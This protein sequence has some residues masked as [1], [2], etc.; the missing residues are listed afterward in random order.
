[1]TRDVKR[2]FV[3]SGLSGSSGQT[4][5]T[6]P[7]DRQTPR[8][9]T[10]DRNDGGQRSCGVRRCIE[11]FRTGR[12][13]LLPLL[14]LVACG[15]DGGGGFDKPED[16]LENP[17]ITDAIEYSGHTVYKGSSPPSI[18][19]RYATFGEVI[20]GTDL[21]IIDLSFESTVCLFNQTAAGRI[22][23][24]EFAGE[25]TGQGAGNITGESS[26]FT[27][28]QELAYQDEYC[29][30]RNALI[31]SGT[32]SADGDLD[33]FG[34]VVILASTNCPGV[35]PGWWARSEGDFLHEGT[36]SGL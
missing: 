12:L 2:P 32:Q 25:A 23:S 3:L 17:W 13:F 1:V 26:T 19:G 36:C 21:S 33:V 14:G 8:V 20:D 4:P 27:V 6:D 28:W 35:R 22:E 7:C 9:L 18:A 24:W 10:W 16:Y 11:A 31:L 30:Q 15:S 29:E 5:A 34:L